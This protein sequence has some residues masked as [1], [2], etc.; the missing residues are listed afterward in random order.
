MFLLKLNLFQNI[1]LFFLTNK[2]I[3]K[4]FLIELKEIINFLIIFN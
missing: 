1:L 4:K 2:F 3:L